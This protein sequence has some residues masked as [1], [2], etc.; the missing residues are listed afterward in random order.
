LIL[1]HNKIS[2][3]AFHPAPFFI[4]LLMSM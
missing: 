2:N 3:K 1:N 4:P